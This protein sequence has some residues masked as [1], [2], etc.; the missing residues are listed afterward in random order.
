MIRDLQ[1]L[2]KALDVAAA[3]NILLQPEVDKV[4]QSLILVHNPLRANVPRKKGSGKQWII[5]KRSVA[6]GTSWVNDTEEISDTASTY[7]A[8]KTFDFKDILF[9]GKVTHKLQLTGLSYTDIKSAEIN[10]GLDAIK[11]DEEDAMINGEVSVDPKQP[12][13]LRKLIPAGQIVE[14]GGAGGDGATLTLKLMDE[15][16]DLCFGLPDMIVCSKRSRREL[17]ALL[18]KAQRFMDRVEV[19]GGFKLQSYND[20]PIYWTP[21]ISDAQ[22]QGGSSDASD[23]FIID[24]TKFWVGILEELRQI[25]LAKISSQYDSF[26]IRESVTNVLANEKYCSRIKGIIPPE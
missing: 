22:T 12:D 7:P 11:T 26:D 10:A 8:W 5:V 24:T 1:E 14:A 19:K 20:I 16:I 23:L 25:P 17:S 21:A 9:K 18:Q 15:A 6:P 2:K 4:I 3:G 13:G